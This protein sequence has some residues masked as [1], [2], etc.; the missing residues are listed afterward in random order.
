MNILYV[1][2]SVRQVTSSEP[3]WLVGQ[4]AV[5]YLSNGNLE[6][7]RQLAVVRDQNNVI[8]TG[9][10][11]STAEGNVHNMRVIQFN[12]D[13]IVLNVCEIIK[14]PV[15]GQVDA[16][17]MNIEV[18]NPAEQTSSHRDYSPTSQI[19]NQNAQRKVTRKKNS[20]QNASIANTGRVMHYARTRTK[21]CLILEGS[22]TSC[23]SNNITGPKIIFASNSF[24]RIINADAS[25]IQGL[26]FLS[27]VAAQDTVA[28]AG[29]LERMATP[30]RIVFDSLR[31]I[32][33][34]VDNALVEAQSRTELS[35]DGAVVTVEVLGA[36]SDDGAIIL[37]Q[38][39]KPRTS[40]INVD[41]EADGYLSLEDIVSSDPNTS[42]APELWK[43]AYL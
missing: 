38:L 41:G 5:Q 39:D 33:D 9:L 24:S 12:C 27:L 10:C 3:S 32:V 4:S 13:N 23:S 43:S 42:D 40:R 11:A 26:P 1:S 16:P 22:L 7:Y 8:I 18:Y 35:S 15:T 30:D 34:P 6:E 20:E 36:G 14:D 17:P 19:S 37:C 25:D 2:S 21:A 29:F 31:F 28:A